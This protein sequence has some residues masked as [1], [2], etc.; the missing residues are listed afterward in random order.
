M[1][2]LLM[3]RKRP[4]SESLFIRAPHPKT[5]IRPEKLTIKRILNLGW[6]GQA[7]IHGHRAQIHLSQDP[8]LPFLVYNRQGRF[9]QKPMPQF[10]EDELRTLFP[11]EKGYTII[12]T[13]WVKP[14]DKVYLFDVLQLN[15]KLLSNYT[16]LE[17]WELLPRVFPS[18]Q[19]ETLPILRTLSE[20]MAV[21]EDPQPH[22]EGLVFKSTTTEGFNDTSI[23]RCRKSSLR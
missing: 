13:E 22:I 8:K 11:A 14:K 18:S 4:K 20:C 3:E 21:L 6:V 1:K 16:Y 7:K 19:I 17:R 9:H 12:D 23:I 15:G 5:E 10:L 2:S